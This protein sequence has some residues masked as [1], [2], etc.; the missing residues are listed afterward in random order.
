[1]RHHQGFLLALDA[2]DLSFH[3]VELPLHENGQS[4][5]GARL[6]LDANYR[7]AGSTFFPTHKSYSF[8]WSNFLEDEAGQS[9]HGADVALDTRHRSMDGTCSRRDLS[10]H[11]VDYHFETLDLSF[12]NVGSPPDEYEDDDYNDPAF[13]FIFIHERCHH[14]IKPEVTLD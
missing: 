9:L 12:E 2:Q 6:S 5:N 11:G 10:F 14:G 13:F 3:V 8:M 4:V 1:M 7:F